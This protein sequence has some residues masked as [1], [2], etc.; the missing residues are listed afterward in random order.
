MSRFPARFEVASPVARLFQSRA[1]PESTEM[2]EEAQ[3]LVQVPRVTL[4]AMIQRIQDL[5]EG[6]MVDISD[7]STTSI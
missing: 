1:L 6:Q 4:R 2:E 7:R 5:E 3:D